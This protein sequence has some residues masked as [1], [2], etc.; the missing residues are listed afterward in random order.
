ML[1][2][3]E[4]R[5]AKIS[6]ELLKDIDKNN[7]K[8]N[9]AWNFD[10]TEL[11]PTVLPA[12]FPNLLVNGSTGISAGYA[13]NIP[14]HNLGEIIDATIKRIEKPNCTLETILEIVKGPDFPTGAI[15]EGKKGITE[16]FQTGRGKIIIK[17][18]YTFVK[19]KGK[20]QILISEIPFE[21]NK[22]QLVK[23]IDE[24]R[25]DK[26]IEGIIEARDESNREG[27]QIAI[28][29]KKDANKELILNYLL[30]NTDLQISYSYN[31]VAIVNKRPMVLGILELLDAYIAHQ[32][33]IIT[34]RTEF[35]LAL[36]RKSVV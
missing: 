2:R 34:K 32:K 23:K 28:D 5:L 10:D 22:Q 29:L 4:A 6:T 18:K 11:E 35:D 3:S 30:K 27:I 21:V 31:M 26:K 1:F 33:E 12:K 17:S 16:A 24:I 9:W 15:V 13:T 7:E 20:E 14:P 36:D 19:S 8:K 25:I